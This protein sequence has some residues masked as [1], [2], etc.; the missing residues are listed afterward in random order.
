MTDVE[1]IQRAA[2]EN[3]IRVLVLDKDSLTWDKIKELI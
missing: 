1:K 3:N 2:T